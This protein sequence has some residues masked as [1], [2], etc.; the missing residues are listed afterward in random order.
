MFW[1]TTLASG[2]AVDPSGHA[3]NRQALR[4]S[5][6]AAREGYAA[7]GLRPSEGKAVADAR[8]ATVVGAELLGPDRLLGAARSR[9]LSIAYIGLVLALRG[10]TTWLGLL[11]FLGTAVFAALFRRPLF[12]VLF[13]S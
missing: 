5:F 7:S 2:I 6:E 4:R 12:S 9:R 1:I 13:F 11:K 8:E 3:R 10:T